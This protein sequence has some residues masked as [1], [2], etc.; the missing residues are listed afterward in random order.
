MLICAR[1]LGVS[2]YNAP[3]GASG[4]CIFEFEDSLGYTVRLC[5]KQFFKKLLRTITIKRNK[6]LLCGTVCVS[7]GITGVHQNAP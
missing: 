6:L 1:V 2:D 7:A 5:L 4:R 3:S